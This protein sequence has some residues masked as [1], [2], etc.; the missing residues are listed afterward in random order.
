MTDYER[1]LRDQLR[2]LR[3][4]EAP[5]ALRAEVANLTNV[6]SHPGRRSWRA[7]VLLVAAAL[8]LTAAMGVIVLGGAPDL[9]PSPAPSSATNDGVLR[10]SAPGISLELP[11]GWSDDSG[12][13]A[14]GEYP[15]QRFVG[16][17]AR[18]MTPCATTFYASDPPT[19]QPS[20][21]SQPREAGSALLTVIEY[22][23]PYPGMKLPGPAVTI[24]GYSGW[25]REMGGM[26]VWLIN[27]PD[28]GAYIFQATAPAA[29]ATRVTEDIRAIL[30]TLRLSAWESPPTAAGGLIHEDAGQG[31]SFDYPDGW[32]RYYPMDLSMMDTAVVTVA[33]G[34][35]LPPCDSADE[36]QRF[37]TP[38]ATVVIEFRAGGGPTAPD[39]SDAP[40]TIGG[41]PAVRNDWIGDTATGAEEGHTW[42]VRLSERDQL[43]IYASLRGPDL[44]TL[45]AAMDAVIASIKIDAEP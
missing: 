17:F 29:E 20:C 33:S 23:Q 14:V 1:R 13:V 37:T 24:A 11:E 26:P 25:Q 3:L 12:L 30:G 22:T 44:A 21:L 18:G 8:A 28:G 41:Q 39:W 7:P 9:P 40:L 6:D 31:F 10:F 42:R 36:C 16:M 19:P 4:P 5:P 45:R 35:V 43:G 15:G 2:G 38:P 32:V 27:A 34:P